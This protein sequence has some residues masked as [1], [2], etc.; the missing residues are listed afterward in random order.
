MVNP[1]RSEARL[2]TF[3][4]IRHC[5]LAGF[6]FYDFL[7]GR[8][9]KKKALERRNVIFPLSDV[10]HDDSK[11]CSSNPREALPGLNLSFQLVP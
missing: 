8:G 1:C 2:R 9:G 3:T 6:T 4:S 11:K 10:S 7:D 5:L